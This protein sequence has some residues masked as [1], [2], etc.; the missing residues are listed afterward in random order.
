MTQPTISETRDRYPHPP[1]VG[2]KGIVGWPRQIFMPQEG[3]KEV[4]AFDY[5]RPTKTSPYTKSR[6]GVVWTDTYIEFVFD[7]DVPLLTVDL[8]PTGI[9]AYQG[10]KDI[11]VGDVPG[12]IEWAKNG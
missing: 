12:F 11:P 5:R 8:G 6:L 10:P 1:D 2:S 7:G 4:Y 3:E 9:R